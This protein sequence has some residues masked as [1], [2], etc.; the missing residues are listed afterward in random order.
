MSKLKKPNEQFAWIPNAIL[1]DRELSLRAK[2]LWVYLN[3]KPDGWIFSIGRIAAE[4]QEGKDAVRSAINELEKAGLLTRTRRSIGTG[5]EEEYEIKAKPCV[6]NSYVGKSHI[7]KSHVGK[8]D[9]LVKQ[10]IDKQNKVKQNKEIVPAPA[11]PAPV[12][13]LPE[14][15]KKLAQ[16]LHKWITIIKPDRKIQSGWEERWARDIEKMHRIDRRSWEAIAACIDWSQRDDFWSQNI[17]SGA[18]L[19]KHYDRMSDR[20]RYDRQKNASQEIGSA[21]FS[22]SDQEAIES[23]KRN[24]LIK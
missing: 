1:N 17:L 11:K 4:H 10:N 18:N 7:G 19:R 20:A 14:E 5:W 9:D 24:G 3:S 16:R 15:A 23:A 22:M 2:G 21:I 6:G 8:S 13:E 12:R